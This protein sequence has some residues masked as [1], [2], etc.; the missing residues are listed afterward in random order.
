MQRR[1]R[2]VGLLVGL[3]L[4]A[5]VA[6]PAVADKKVDSTQADATKTATTKPAK[7]AIIAVYN[8]RGELKDG[9]PTLA[10][11]LDLRTPQSLFKLLERFRKI[12]KDNEV[13]AVLLSISDLALGWGQMQELRQ[14]ILGLRAAKKDVYCYLEDASPSV[15]LLA[16]AAS[17]ISIVPTG[18]IALMGM[19]VEQ[20]YFKGLMDKIGVEAD[21]EHM[22][23]FK[24]AGEPF[25]RTGPSEQARQMIEWLVK[26]LFEQMIKTVSQGRDIPFDKVRSLIDQGPFNARQ[27]L[28]A[29]LVD[30]A[31]YADELVDALRDRY[32]DDARFV[33]NYGA[34][35]RAQLDLSSPF[36]IF[37]LLG[38][39]ASKGKPSAKPAVAVV[40]LDGMIVTGRT[41]QSP[42]GDAGTVGS[43]SLRHAL[44][45]AASDK[46]VKAVV[47]R[48]NSPGG[49]AT[50][51]DIIWRAASELGKEKPLV[52][53]MG[54]MAASGGYYV[55]AGARAIFADRGTITGSIGVLTGKIV[56]KGLWDWVGITFHETT[57]G[58]NADLFNT[59]RRFD[60]RQR[61]IVR[62]HLENIYKEFTDRVMAGRGNKLKKD[63][64]ELAG[65]RVF[66]GRQA[67]ANGLVDRL[68]GL[69]DAV[70]YA[71]K[72]ADLSEDEYELRVLPEPK[73]FMDL[74]IRSLTGQEE[75]DEGV[76]VAVTIDEPWTLK[77]PFARELLPALKALDP[78]RAKLVL[79]S[80]LRIELLGREHVLLAL[81]CE[82]SIR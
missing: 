6:A 7:P 19:H 34:D 57:M 12:E 55:S 62:E 69:Q 17:R 70:S 16:T 45:R 78:D 24:G 38:E 64:S 43:T 80:L 49:S 14:A 52:V 65:G 47:L 54:D 60:D 40:Y 73:N 26:D 59:N 4:L 32:G 50:A 66:T 56:T 53:S 77:L 31:I 75:D 30:H 48:V 72:L 37:K 44:A 22:G 20:A 18:E 41:E 76:D 9:P 8:L 51:S 82:I 36:A 63:L 35:K 71:A 27:A 3:A 28:E 74:F 13:K 10:V 1:K 79:R 46:S 5:I 58:Q 21:I 11:S 61:A 33:Q 25:T 39:S 81:P 42:F 15:Y 23:E 68:G 2:V 67:E 29:K